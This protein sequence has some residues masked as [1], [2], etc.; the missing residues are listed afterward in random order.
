[1]ISLALLTNSQPQQTAPRGAFLA[2]CLLLLSLLTPWPVSATPLN[3][4]NP[5]SLSADLAPIASASSPMNLTLSPVSFFLE[6]N[7]GEPTTATLKIRNN[8]LETE[9]LQI[10]FGSFVADQTGNQPQLITP[11]PS[12]PAQEW[13][14]A[15]P[16]Q[17][18]V[19]PGEWQEVTIEF[20]PPATAALSYNYS[21]L[22]QR[23]LNPL[24]PG[25]AAIKGSPAVLAVGFV[26]SP[27]S[28]RHLELTELR[29]VE[30]VAEYLPQRFQL[31]LRNTGNVP[32]IPSGN[33]F[34]DG[35]GRSDLAVLSINPQSLVVLPG[36]SRTIE[37]SW[38]DG[39]PVKSGSQDPAQ[40]GSHL[41]GGFWDISR[42]QSFRLGK[43][44]T[45]AI[46]V[47]DNG[48]RD[49]PLEAFVSFWVVPWKV[50]LIMAGMI[51]LAG[52]G[53]RSLL[54]SLWQLASKKGH[55][56]QL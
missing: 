19:P 1:M 35:Q 46:V 24:R 4:S 53:L 45:H 31:Q 15:S 38:Q 2:S 18:L 51:V 17:F 39:F 27:L 30:P 28:Q 22:V 50:L 13:I 14:S 7:P 6:T 56:H 29:V 36:A 40:L 41:L 16:S 12:N 43:Y 54:A 3:P 52:L 25:E 42:A 49:I 20:A 5:A 33:L 34:I 8:S 55:D 23:L 44:T 11:E 47:Y 21:I 9:Q 26:R 10:Q 32:I 37:V 48:E